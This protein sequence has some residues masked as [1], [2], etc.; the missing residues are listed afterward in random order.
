MHKGYGNLKDKATNICRRGPR[1]LGPLRPPDQDAGDEYPGE[2]AGAR[3]QGGGG[4][5]QAG[6][7]PEAALQDI[8]GRERGTVTVI[9]PPDKLS[10]RRTERTKQMKVCRTRP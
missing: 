7:P 8:S 1:L 2:A 5:Q 4:A 9:L 3:E 6:P 10:R